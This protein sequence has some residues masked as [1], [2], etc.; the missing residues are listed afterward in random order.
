ML[1]A[2]FTAAS[3]PTVQTA[4]R[5]LF[6]F[7]QNQKGNR[8][9]EA[10][11]NPMTYDQAATPFQKSQGLVDNLSNFSNFSGQAMDL[12]GMQGNQAAQSA[13]MMGMGGSAANMLRNRM[14]A[15]GI[16][17]AYSNF[18]QAAPQIANMQL[19]IDKNIAQKMYGDDQFQRD[20][21]LLRGDQNRLTGSQNMAA[22]ATQLFGPDG[23]NAQERQEA[24]GAIGNV[25][26]RD[27]LGGMMATGVGG[28]LQ[29]ARD[30]RNFFSG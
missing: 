27:G 4:A 29:G 30:I 6:G 9:M 22:A 16:N 15:S 5:G 11:T 12:S 26:G 17:Q 21:R 20:F 24:F 14:R 23:P 19:G 18:L 8:M 10:A 13:A 25:L 1:G 7:L 3:N 2:L 28:L